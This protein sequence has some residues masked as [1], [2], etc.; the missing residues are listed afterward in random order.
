MSLLRVQALW[1]AY[2]AALSASTVAHTRVSTCLARR[3]SVLPQCMDGS[4]DLT[5]SHKSWYKRNY[6]CV[7]Q[8]VGALSDAMAEAGLD[9]EATLGPIEEEYWLMQ[10]LCEQ[11]DGDGAEEEGEKGEGSGVQDLGV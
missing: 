4:S 7:T 1:Q 8:E 11:D 5:A 6:C 10:Q 9:P 3:E 2:P